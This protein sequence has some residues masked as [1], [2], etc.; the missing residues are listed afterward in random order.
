MYAIFPV[1]LMMLPENLYFLEKALENLMCAI[2]RLSRHESSRPL[3]CMEVAATAAT[4][5]L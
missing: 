1:A 4:S 5:P 3:G 2:F